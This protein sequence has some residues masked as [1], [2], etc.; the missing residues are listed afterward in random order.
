MIKV[1]ITVSDISNTMLMYDRINIYTSDS[2]TGTYT[3]SDYVLLQAGVSEYEYFDCD[4]DEDTWYKSSYYNSSSENESSLSNAAQGSIPSLYHT[5][6]YP[7][8]Y[9]FNAD[10]DIVV[11]KIRR[12]IGDLK[13]LE[14][15]Y[16]DTDDFCNYVLGDNHT[17]DLG[18]KG[19]P[20]YISVNS[21]EYTTLENP[22]VQ[23]YRYLTFSGTLQTG[24][25]NDTMELWYHTFKFS[26][27]EV[28]QA[29][30][31]VIMPPML[32]ST[33]VTK[34][35]LILQTAIDLLENMW[36]E[37]MVDDGASVRDD[38]TLYDPSPGL[39]ERDKLIARL[40]KRL[41]ALINESIKNAM[42]G[43]EGVLID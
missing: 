37:D 25:T 29:Y 43:L 8:E 11:R 16:V 22:V 23:G 33:T 40:Q 12:L 31:D 35:H 26:D 19:W 36:A 13:Q 1:T 15:K 21:T 38:Q 20:V 3:Y 34:D 28:F 18:E 39:K 41:D 7:E 5:V 24:N 27:R 6:T 42:L 9:E 32:T 30:A 4:G 2:E 17:V 14:H 10:E